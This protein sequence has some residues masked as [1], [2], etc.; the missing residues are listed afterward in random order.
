MLKSKPIQM[1]TTNFT[2]EESFQLIDSVIQKA[3]SRFEENGIPF[4]LWGV[5]IALCSYAQAYMI[6]INMSRE[7][8]YPYLIM[9]FV[10]IGLFIYYYN[11]KKNSTPNPLASIYGRLWQF[12][13]L[14]IMLIAFGFNGYLQNNLVPIILLLMGIATLLS[15]S[16]IKSKVLFFSGL[17]IN[18]SAFISFFLSWEQQPLLM[19]TVS[20]FALLI[21]GILLRLNHKK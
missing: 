14:N 1:K 5:I 2:P 16:Y 9:P 15:G 3:K 18:T 19:G 4:I 8:W 13:G 11:K 12:V 7:S 20:I 21:P 10:G 6:S 17:I